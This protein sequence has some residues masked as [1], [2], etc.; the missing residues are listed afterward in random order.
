MKAT[1]QRIV[2]VM[3]LVLGLLLTLNLFAQNE[4]ASVRGQ[5][6]DPSG[7]LIPGAIVRFTAGDAKV[8]SALT[9]S[10]GSYELKNLPAETYTVTVTAPGFESLEQANVVVAA[11]RTGQHDFALSIAVEKQDVTVNEQSNSVDTS[12][13]NNASQIVIKGAALDALS[14]D[15]DEL[16]SELNALAGPS[17]GP[18]GGQIFIDGFSGGQLPPK[19]SIREI[20]VN[21]NPFSAQYDKLGYGRIE[22][23]TKPGTDKMHG[24]L[25]MNGNDSAFNSLNPFVTS[26]PPYYSTFMMGNLSGSLRKN[27]S[28]F[29]SVFRR[30]QQ[31]NTI[32]NADT[33]VDADGSAVALTGAYS[34]PRTRLDISPRIDLQITPN[35]TLTVRY[36]YDRVS[37]TGDGVGQLALS[38]QAYNRAD[39]EQSLQ[40]SD[41]Q[42]LGNNAL[43]ETLFQYLRSRNSSSAQ[44]TDP[45][46]LVQGAF[47]GGGNTIGELLDK[48][49]R[50]ELQNNT[51]LVHGSHSIKFGTR[52]RAIRDVNS[53]TNG[54]NGTFTFST[55]A[56]YDALKPSQYSVMK[57]SPT[58]NVT[59]FDASLYAADEWRVRPNLTLSYGLRY[60]AQNHLN[61]YLNFAPRLS[62]AW[63]T[64]KGKTIVRAGYGWFYDR[65]DYNYIL[66]A[67]RQNG[68]T[69]RQYIVN[70]PTTGLTPPSLDNATISPTI[71]QVDPH[72][73]TPLTMEAAIGVDRQITKNATVSVT[74]I[75]S[76]GV[77]ALFSDNINAPLPETG[78]RPNGTN[79]NIYQYQSGG[80]FRQSQLVTNFSVRSHNVS[81]FGFYMLNLA[82]GDT[83]GANSF[84]SN[85]YDPGADYGR[86]AFDVRN[87]LL[88]GGNIPLKYGLAFSPMIVANSGAPFNVTSGIDFNGDS[89]FNDRPAFATDLSRPS[90]VRTSL[91]NFDTQPMAGQ[92]IIPINYG[93]GPSQFSA[94]I[95]L[96]KRF[97]IGPKTEGGFTSGGG[98]GGPPP[99]GGGPGGPG[100]GGP[101]GGGAAGG[102]GPGGLSG[103][104]GPPQLDAPITRRYSLGFAV[105][106][107]NV[108]N[109]VNLAQPVGVV[110]ASSFNTST[111]LAG[112]FFSS[113][114]ANR[115]I[116][117]QMN[118]SF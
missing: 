113:Q 39:T 7:A 33:S 83:T 98:Q 68:I 11:G 10:S 18:N 37:E 42:V 41:T 99:G 73:H 60:E 22:I 63:A 1:H 40:L 54:F 24:S 32:V 110:T 106:A 8:F 108:F 66:Q 100:G 20:R 30:N 89:I 101:G 62:A 104:N 61:D 111:A 29:V 76:R 80:V 97:A 53:S 86:S 94:N 91:G 4:T 64:N 81:L 112:G 96:S 90:V 114:S 75:N 58:S 115:S 85:S 79:E 27:A 28:F 48:Q 38:S 5:V 45:T 69:Q 77:H 88:I 93:T 14:D 65:F 109:N 57:G 12:S 16:Q 117:L 50:F 36:L 52:L 95:R 17:A 25:M 19:S 43:N 118:F 34:N 51:S 82:N 84:P 92:T 59:V 103:K 74:Y 71:Y 49:D 46:I 13:D 78:L 31:D 9:S 107:H 23:L 2:S 26:E 116:D 55:L 102:L 47:I 70:L 56:D 6:T 105:M 67:E 35:N 21:Q 44:S 72:M 3:F 15:P 87:R